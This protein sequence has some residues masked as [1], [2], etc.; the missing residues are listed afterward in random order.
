MNAYLL[1]GL[2]IF[3][4]G[5]P[6]RKPVDTA[7]S[8]PLA[9]RL[10]CDGSTAPND[11]LPVIVTFSSGNW[12]REFLI[13]RFQKEHC[14]VDLGLTCLHTEKAGWHDAWSAVSV[15]PSA[16]TMLSLASCYAWGS[17]EPAQY[18][19]SGWYKEGAPEAKLEWRQASIKRISSQPDIYEFTDP[20]GGTARLEFKPW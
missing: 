14:G 7:N 20:K 3:G 5:Q 19:L 10:Q 17:R 16:G 11:N 6:A 4:I 9:S 2:L 18:V 1:A 12:A 8:L 15:T 13:S